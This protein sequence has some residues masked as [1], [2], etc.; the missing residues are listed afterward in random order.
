MIETISKIFYALFP[1]VKARK[2]IIIELRENAEWQNKRQD[3]LEE[4]IDKLETLY[5]RDA[6]LRLNCSGRINLQAPY[7][8]PQRKKKNRQ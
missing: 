4:R 7:T 6:C 1:S 8:P 3:Q 5:K 2:D